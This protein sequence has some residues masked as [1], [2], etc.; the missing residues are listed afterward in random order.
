[1]YLTDLDGR[2]RHLVGNRE[3]VK[4]DSEGF[5]NSPGSIV[6][7]SKGNF[8]VADSGNNRIQAFSKN[9]QFITVI[10]VGFIRRPAGLQLD[11]YSRLFMLSTKDAEVY[12]MKLSHQAENEQYERPMSKGSQN[13]FSKKKKDGRIQE[14]VNR[15][16]TGYNRGINRGN[17][18][19]RGNYKEFNNPQNNFFE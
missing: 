15:G 16:N 3:F 13:F 4:S 17:R 14:G 10:D 11:D 7:D 1:V 18:R 12:A 9:G 8:I 6:V 2:L 19:G 5:F